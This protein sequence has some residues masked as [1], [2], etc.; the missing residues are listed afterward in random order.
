[1]SNTGS[2][3]LDVLIITAMLLALMPAV[4]LAYRKD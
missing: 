1:M 3:T 2:W 4:S